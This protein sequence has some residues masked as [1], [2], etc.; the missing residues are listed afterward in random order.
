MYYSTGRLDM[1]LKCADINSVSSFRDCIA[2]E[3][4]VIRRTGILQQGE[5]TKISL[6]TIWP[7]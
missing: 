4:T 5:P 6:A 3:E 2:G 7:I 1:P